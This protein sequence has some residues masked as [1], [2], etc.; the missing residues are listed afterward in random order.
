MWGGGGAEAGG[1]EYKRTK[2]RWTIGTVNH[3]IINL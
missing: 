2:S 3:G 1:I